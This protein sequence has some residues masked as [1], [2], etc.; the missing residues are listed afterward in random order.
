LKSGSPKNLKPMHK[1]KPIELSN[2]R[3][4]AVECSVRYNTS[5][6]TKNSR[7][8]FISIDGVS[9]SAEKSPTQSQHDKTQ[10]K[11]TRTKPKPTT[12]PEVKKKAESKVK[13]EAKEKNNKGR[14][15]ER[16]K[17]KNKVLKKQEVVYEV[18]DRQID[19]D[20][21][22]LKYF[23]GESAVPPEVESLMAGFTDYTDELVAAEYNKSANEEPILEIIKER[24]SEHF[25]KDQLNEG[26]NPL[27]SEKIE[28]F[29]KDV[30]KLAVT[31]D[32]TK[33]IGL[34]DTK[35]LCRGLAY[36]IRQHI[37]FSRGKKMLSELPNNESEEFLQQALNAPLKEKPPQIEVNT[38]KAKEILSESIAM[39]TDTEIKP[40]MLKS[41]LTIEESN[42]IDLTY[43]KSQLGEIFGKE[44]SNVFL[45]S[46]QNNMGFF[47]ASNEARSNLLK[48]Q[49]IDQLTI[50][51]LNKYLESCII[52]PTD[53]L[54]KEDDEICTLSDDSQKDQ[55]ESLDESN[56]LDEFAVFNLNYDFDV[57]EF[58]DI[59]TI[60]AQYLEVP[61]EREVY[62]FCKKLLIYGKMEK[63]VSIVALIYIEK[64]IIKT[65]L[66]MNEL[67]WR[68]FL[69]TALVLASKV[70]DD[71][72]FENI[73]FTKAFPDVSIKQINELERIYLKCLDYQLN[74]N[75]S[76]Y[77]KYYFILRTISDKTNTK[78]PL[79]PIEVKKV[80]QLQR[81]AIKVQ[82]N[83]KSV[84]ELMAKTY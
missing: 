47:K 2:A 59:S 43:T 23:F 42:D 63:E 18:D 28:E 49:V 44:S 38:E 33:E 7:K 8:A 64:V 31:C 21:L 17:E 39:M 34:P 70:W 79:K 50:Q 41:Y 71:Q 1:K 61:S 53:E 10:Q 36:V 55:E 82:K 54:I 29:K 32:L 3:L 25:P 15:K 57:M 12:K 45:K 26:M 72:S 74:I 6:T 35:S 22:G 51:G 77:A 19:Q 5:S 46:Y 52:K 4:K 73:H 56:L 9:L 48:T 81:N 14:H 24:P 75:G 62:K 69:F 78:C 27:A 67:N 30:K 16:I 65:G 60:P 11:P 84:N 58:N 76:E 66:L 37:V 68:H 80:V 40:E 83:I 13:V 20:G